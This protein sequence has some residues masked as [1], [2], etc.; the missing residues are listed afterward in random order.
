M[1][2]CSE[3]TKRIVKIIKFSDNQGAKDF[4]LT[5]NLIKVLSWTHLLTFLKLS[6]P[7]LQVSLFI[8]SEML[9]YFGDYWCS[10]EHVFSSSFTCKV[11]ESFENEKNQFTLKR[12]GSHSTGFAHNWISFFQNCKLNFMRMKLSLM[13]G[14]HISQTM[15]NHFRIYY[16]LLNVEIKRI[17]IAVDQSVIKP[18]MR[19]T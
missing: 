2:C 4:S 7:F 5:F 11:V 19:L 14:I 16:F 10:S 8:H 18:G 9:Q 13:F 6:C 15:H 3:T 17:I 1:I 12:N